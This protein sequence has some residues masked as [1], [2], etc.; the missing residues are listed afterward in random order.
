MSV[1][2]GVSAANKRISQI[3]GGDCCIAAGIERLERIADLVTQIGI[4]KP[5]AQAAMAERCGIRHAAEMGLAVRI[6]ATLDKLRRK[7]AA[8]TKLI[9]ATIG[10]IDVEHKT[11]APL[12][13]GLPP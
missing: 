10:T 7:N 2:I 4:S 1:K 6:A 3:G 11:Q 12:A 13:V 8:Q 5:A 9:A